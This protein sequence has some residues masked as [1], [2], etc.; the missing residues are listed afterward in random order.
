MLGLDREQLQARHHTIHDAIRCGNLADVRRKIQAGDANDRDCYGLTPLDIAIGYNSKEIAELLITGGAYIS[1]AKDETLSLAVFLGYYENIRSTITKRPFAYHLNNGYTG[2]TVMSIF[3]YVALILM[4]SFTLCFTMNPV[5]ADSFAASVN[6]HSVPTLGLLTLLTPITFYGVPFIATFLIYTFIDICYFHACT[7]RKLE[8]CQQMDGLLH[9]AVKIGNLYAVRRLIGTDVNIDLQ[10]NSSVTALSI[11]INR[12]DLNIIEELI[13]SGADSGSHLCSS[14]YWN[15]CKAEVELMRGIELGKIGDQSVTLCD[16]LRTR[17][18]TKLARCFINEEI[19][20]NLEELRSNNFQQFPM[21]ANILSSKVEKG[22]KISS[23]YKRI[24]T[25]SINGKEIIPISDSVANPLE[26]V[27]I[28]QY[29]NKFLGN[30][31]KSR[32]NLLLAHCS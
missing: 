22:E 8:R 9:H 26:K 29:V 24:D 21:Y 23:L 3:P 14:P 7:V 17:D 28:T 30:D 18:D 16:F 20:Q 2:D 11:A 19:R 12:R 10:D 5:L 1:K 25:G 13:A 6:M 32:L 15:R 4:A 31:H 27:I